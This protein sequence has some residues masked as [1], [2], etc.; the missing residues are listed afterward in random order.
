MLSNFYKIIKIVLLVLL[1]HS[2]IS[3]DLT[4]PERFYNSA[5][6]NN[7][8]GSI[9]FFELNDNQHFAG[10]MDIGFSLDSISF[11]ISGIQVFVDSLRVYNFSAAADTIN[12][13][14]NTTR[15]PDGPHNLKVVLT[16]ND[17][18]YYTLLDVPILEFDKVIVFDQS[19]PE[20]VT[21][22][23]Y[24][25]TNNHPELFW[26]ESS[27]LNFRYYIIRKAYDGIISSIDTID[28][29]GTTSYTDTSIIK[30]SGD[31]IAVYSII[32][33]N[34][35]EGS[36]SNEMSVSYGQKLPLLLYDDFMYHSA[37]QI[38][39]KDIMINLAKD[40]SKVK[41]M[42]Y[43]NGPVIH[44]LPIV[45]PF[46]IS[47][48]YGED[49]IYILGESSPDKLYK[50]DLRSYELN[51]LTQFGGELSYIASIIEGKNQRLF[52]FGAYIELYNIPT[53][54]KLYSKWID[55]HSRAAEM[56]FSPDSTLLYAASNY[57]LYCLSLDGDS[58]T[59]INTVHSPLY[60]LQDL[61]YE[62]NTGRL[63]ARGTYPTTIDFID[64]DSL[65][66]VSSFIQGS[67]IYPNDLYP[68]GSY[69]FAAF[70]DNSEADNAKGLVIKYD[71][72][73]MQ[74]LKEWKFKDI[75][76]NILVLKGSNKMIAYTYNYLISGKYCT[77]WLVDLD[78]E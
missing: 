18:G 13:T 50:L 10:I 26:T 48:N 67:R 38:P 51:S 77:G 73:T 28:E 57:N 61:F 60:R 54:E 66:L 55:G 12:F 19:V 1:T 68:D 63:I 44:A 74:V 45:N 70:S 46:S 56:C 14:I 27:S 49:H 71:V 29:R 34:G 47:E 58:V 4:E 72:S 36:W 35:A 75:V 69:L 5:P 39:G 7:P 3:C 52:A 22:N 8:R 42:T 59:F 37:Q 53:G 30:V 25:W 21:L 64:P 16:A 24:Q 9:D 6:E 11:S 40:S 76:K 17:M 65:T 32:V 20:P 31:D 78:Q 41:I 62:P 33:S 2:L 15:Y 43:D 23:S